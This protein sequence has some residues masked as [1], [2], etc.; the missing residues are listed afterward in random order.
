MTFDLAMEATAEIQGE[1]RQELGLPA[2]V[3]VQDALQRLGFDSKAFG[4]VSDGMWLGPRGRLLPGQRVLVTPK[5]LGGGGDGG[6]TG[7]EDR[8]AVKDMHLI[9]KR[10]ADATDPKEERRERWE[11]CAL[12][13]EPL[14]PGSV[15]MDEVGTLYNY[16]PVLKA[17]VANRKEGVAL[18]SALSHVRGKKDLLPLRIGKQ[19]DFASA[20]GTGETFACPVT[21]LPFNGTFRFV[22]LKPSGVVVSE[23]AL[24]RH[25]EVVE[26]LL[27]EG[28]AL[29]EQ[30][31]LS[32]NPEGKELERARERMAKR[33]SQVEKTRGS[34]KRQGGGGDAVAGEAL[35]RASKRSKAL[36]HCPDVADKRVWSSIFTGTTD[37]Q[38]TRETFTARALSGRNT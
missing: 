6:V 13:A 12:T 21:A 17:I 10:K 11:R 18:P 8:R 5:S 30:E 29:K 25:P 15:V 3:K 2:Y 24:T 16:E 27:P 20:S 22:A 31:R 37:R 34:V 23:R 7:A 38:P 32:V 19:Q 1:A 4:M 28:A 36:E 35:D 14:E 9:G 26:E 33:T